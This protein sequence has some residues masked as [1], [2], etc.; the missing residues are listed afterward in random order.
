LSQDREAN[1]TFA[2]SSP[3]HVSLRVS[4]QE[5]RVTQAKVHAPPIAIESI[6]DGAAPKVLPCDAGVSRTSP[7]LL[8]GAGNHT[9]KAHL[10]GGLRPLA[11]L[12]VLS[13]RPMG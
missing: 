9:L 5:L 13:D 6:L 7:A 4:P 1:L 3:A 2:L 12:W 10:L 11:R 8:L